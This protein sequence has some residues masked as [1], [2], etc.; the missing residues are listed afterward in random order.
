[1]NSKMIELAFLTYFVS[2]YF[3]IINKNAQV[4]HLILIFKHFLTKI[5]T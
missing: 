4:A 5:K 1:M 2:K 3:I